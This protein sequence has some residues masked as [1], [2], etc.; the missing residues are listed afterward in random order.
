MR[1]ILYTRVIN[2]CHSPI[3]ITP[4]IIKNPEVLSG[5]SDVFRGV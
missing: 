1:I 5:F 3:S 2:S 4:E